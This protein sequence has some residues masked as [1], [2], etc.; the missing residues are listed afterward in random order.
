MKYAV[1]VAVLLCAAWL[2]PFADAINEG[3]ALYA[4]RK[5]AEAEA[6]YSRAAGFADDVDE[7]AA[8]AY[9]QGAAV[10]MQG[11]HERAADFFRQGLDSSDREIQTR[12]LFALGNALYRIKDY[13]GAA[14][15]WINTLKLDPRHEG[16]R[17]NLEYLL[18]PQQNEQNEQNQQNQQ[19]DGEQNSGNEQGEGN[20]QQNPQQGGQNS[21]DDGKGQQNGQN[22]QN[23]A[24]SGQRDQGGR[25]GSGRLDADQ[26]EAMLR[27]MRNKPVRRE[28]GYREGEGESDNGGW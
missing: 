27:A 15:A 22:R 9:S 1:L 19:Q 16:A 21:A 24:D 23:N 8:S 4:D 2:D 5:Y 3:N 12:S 6:A 18:R 13:A 28:G 25:A 20:K 26:V 17:K 10:Y 14:D 7:K 11:K